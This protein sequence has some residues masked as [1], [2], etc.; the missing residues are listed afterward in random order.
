MAAIAP[1]ICLTGGAG[2]DTVAPSAVVPVRRHH[3]ACRFTAARQV[4]PGHPSTAEHISSNWRRRVSGIR[5]RALPFLEAIELPLPGL[6]QLLP[7]LQGIP[8][9]PLPLEQR[10]ARSPRG[11]DAATLESHELRAVWRGQVR[12]LPPSDAP[13]PGAGNGRHVILQVRA[14]C[15]YSDPKTKPKIVH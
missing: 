11:S 5:V 6:G 8:R 4:S 9:L 2:L 3:A 1:G 10:P 15:A 13:Q 14:S 12:G 7:G